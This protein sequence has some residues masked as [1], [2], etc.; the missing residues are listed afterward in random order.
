ME[1]KK[2]S[3]MRTTFNSKGLEQSKRFYTEQELRN[4]F[5]R[6]NKNPAFVE[7]FFRRLYANSGVKTIDGLYQLVATLDVT[8][9]EALI[10][11]EKRSNN[12]SKNKKSYFKG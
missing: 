8:W 3:I 12:G 10:L 11:A 9:A 5:A 7:E 6:S 4:E 2:F 1:A